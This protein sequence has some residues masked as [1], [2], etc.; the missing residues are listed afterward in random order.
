MYGLSDEEIAA[1]REARIEAFAPA[2][3]ALL[4]MADTL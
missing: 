1:I 4:R 3:V 2:E